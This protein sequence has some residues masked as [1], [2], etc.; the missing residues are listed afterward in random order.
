[1]GQ[2]WQRV[3][4]YLHSLQAYQD[5]SPDLS[6]RRQVN[7][8]LR[9]HRRPLSAQAWCAECH[10]ATRAQSKTLAFIYRSLKDYSGLEFSLVRPQDRLVDDLQFPLVCWF[11]WSMRLCD[12]VV[13]QF[14]V[15]ISDHFDETQL[16]TLADL[17]SCVDDCVRRAA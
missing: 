12:D 1:M 2:P 8:A 4:N 16:D 3:N 10:R 15:D 14:G 11:D 13:N 17:I 7:Q 6:V 5:M 9:R